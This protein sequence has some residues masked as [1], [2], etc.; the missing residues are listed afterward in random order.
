MSGLSGPGRA[1]AARGQKSRFSEEAFAQDVIAVS[2]PVSTHTFD[3]SES[4]HAEISIIVECLP[5]SMLT[6]NDNCLVGANA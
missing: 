1:A 4:R 6:S 3:S 2:D 5:K